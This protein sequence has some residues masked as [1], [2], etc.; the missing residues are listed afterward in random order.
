MQMRGTVEYSGRRYNKKKIYKLK[1][2]HVKKEKIKNCSSYG[3]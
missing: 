1:T 3:K 2:M